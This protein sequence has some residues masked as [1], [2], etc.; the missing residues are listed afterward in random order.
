[1]KGKLQLRYLV[2]FKSWAV[3]RKQRA[4]IDE[5]EESSECTIL[6][7]WCGVSG[8]IFRH[9]L[10]SGQ[11]AGFA[12]AA[13][14]NIVCFEHVACLRR[15]FVLKLEANIFPALGNLLNFCL[16]NVCEVI[17][18]GHFK[19]VAAGGAIVSKAACAFPSAPCEFAGSLHTVTSFDPPS[20]TK[21]GNC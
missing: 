16:A 7:I 21:R 14:L 13:A 10:Q 18:A 5:W 8:W 2:G 15:R 3:V 19:S 20:K 9:W 12:L 1:M 6:T 11:T 17:P 4:V